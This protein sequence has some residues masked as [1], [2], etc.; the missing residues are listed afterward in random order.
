MASSVELPRWSIID[1]H[2]SLDARSFQASME[3]LTA[4]VSRLEILFEQH[5]I[6]AASDRAPTVDDGAA[7]DRIVRNYNSALDT[8]ELLD[9]CVYA[10]VS[11]NS[12]DEHAQ[13]LLSQLADTD[14]KLRPLLA[15]LADWV[16]SLGVDALATLSDEVQ[17]HLQPLTRL[18]QRASHQMS[19]AE[20]G[21]YSELAT[22]GSTAWG[23]LQSDVT[24][25]LAGT[26]KH[27]DGTVERL[28]MPAV[29][30]LANH[31]DEAVRKA[32]YEAELE[33]WPTIATPVAAALNAIKGEA[34]TIN[35]R[36]NW[37]SP[38]DASLFANG[39]SR[40]TFDAMQAAVSDALPDLQRWLRLKNA[41]H[42]STEPQET[43]IDQGDRR[44]G[45]PWWNLMAPAPVGAGSIGWNEGIDIVRAAFAKFSPQLGHLVDRAIDD[46]RRID[47][48]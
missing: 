16:A 4:E 27:A 31:P 20:E 46:A 43:R 2:E 29:R 19:E 41:L 47:P 9:A 21:L 40:P 45:L 30:G 48:V 13:A 44:D 14:A 7:A 39:V 33:A 5:D 11:T 1:V 36:R 18:A 32:A 23:R 10:T 42:V 26:V 37:D 38:L 15:R 28:P 35:R 8:L 17:N 24:S 34:N 6:R 25:Q 12:R 3:R 22:S